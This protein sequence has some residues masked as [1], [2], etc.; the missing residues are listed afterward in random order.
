[1]PRQIWLVDDSPRWHEV[2]A[3]SLLAVPGWELQGFHTG[4]AALHAFALQAATDATR[5]PDAILMDFYLG[6]TRGDHVTTALRDMEPEGCHCTIVGH[7]TSPSGS[8]A[9]VAA[10]ADLVIP[11][12]A[13]RQ[14]RNPDLVAWLQEWDAD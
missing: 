6:A 1:M 9:I 10:G 2:A 11:K 4:A 13:D 14:G 12:Y 3:D 8:E 5:L 7:S